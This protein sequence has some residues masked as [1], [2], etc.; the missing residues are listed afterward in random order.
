MDDRTSV[1]TGVFEL[2]TIDTLSDTRDLLAHATKEA[3]KLKDY[4]VVDSDGHLSEFP[5]WQEI[6]ARMDN[7]VYRDMAQSF[8][9]RP[10]SPAGG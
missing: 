10:G 7:K 9:E 4:F 8:K 6:I 5:F 1:P 2:P 3:E